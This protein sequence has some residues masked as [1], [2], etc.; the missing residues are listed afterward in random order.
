[1]ATHMR[2][3]GHDVVVITTSVAG[4]IEGEAGVIRTPDL[5]ATPA[6]RRALGAAPLPGPG[7][8]LPGYSQATTY[9]RIL[10]PDPKLLGWVP[11]ALAATRRV[12]RRLPVDCVI[13]SSPFE[14]THLI[15]FGLGPRR[16]PWVADLQDGWSF[17]SWR[18]SLPLSL[19]RRVDGWLERQVLT[20]AD[21]VTALP[22]AVAADVRRRF[23]RTAHHITDGWDPELERE[24]PQVPATGLHPDRVTLLHTGTLW[25]HGQDPSPL[26]EALQRLRVEDPGLGARLELVLAGPL[27]SAEELRLRQF[28]L[29]GVV[30]HVG[31]LS[32]V[33]AVAL[34]R[35]ADALLIVGP[36]QRDAV[37]GKIFEYLASGRPIVVLPDQG[38]AAAVVRNTRT[39]VAVALDDQAAMV[40]V[41]LDV[42]TGALKTTY[43]PCGLDAYRYP[44]PAKAM[45]EVVHEAIS[46]AAERLTVR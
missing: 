33:E 26:F 4:R 38:E 3:L 12:L 15:G 46:R 37:T 32:R 23:R 7:E 41:L 45:I 22:R 11:G 28:R 14:S 44:A 39:G 6:L 24:L 35:R 9:E 19:Q 1:M 43:R 31:H 10:V 21:A 13:T 29:D 34:Q 42:V 8:P 36:G 25:R 27:S 5:F 17:E 20:G 30:R 2:S 16:P 40:Q 18:P